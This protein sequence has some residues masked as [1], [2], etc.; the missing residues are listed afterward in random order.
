MPVSCA[1]NSRFTI[2]KFVLISQEVLLSG[3]YDVELMNLENKVELKLLQNQAVAKYIECEFSSILISK[4]HNFVLSVF[5]RETE[6]L[7]ASSEVLSSTC[8]ESDE[9]EEDENCSVLVEAY[10]RLYKKFR[11]T[12]Q[13]CEEFDQLRAAKEELKFSFHERKQELER[14]TK[15]FE[16]MKNEPKQKEMSKSRR[17]ILFFIN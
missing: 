14:L 2:S 11:S 15:Q 6:K 3:I 8:D 1:L 17:E 5:E 16:A 10:T 13:K 12:P 4:F 7:K 9:D